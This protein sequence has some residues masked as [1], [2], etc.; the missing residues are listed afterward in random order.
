MAAAIA[1]LQATTVA[2]FAD[3]I[4]PTATPSPRIRPV[5]TADDGST[6]T[7]ATIDVP[8][9]WT[10]NGEGC[11]SPTPT[12]ARQCQGTSSARP[13][14]RRPAAPATRA[15]ARRWISAAAIQEK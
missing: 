7:S 13:S 11:P 4:P 8:T 14:R 15:P 9:D 5:S 3:T 1:A 6:A 10:P 12:F 2:V